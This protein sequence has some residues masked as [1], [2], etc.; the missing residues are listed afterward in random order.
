VKKAQ[1]YNESGVFKIA[2]VDFGLKY[3][4]IRMLCQLGACVHVVPWD[5]DL[6]IDGNF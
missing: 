1:V 6:N 2:V 4:Q 5:F 3:N